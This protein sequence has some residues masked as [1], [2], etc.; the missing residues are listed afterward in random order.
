MS[1]NNP[2]E[3]GRVSEETEGLGPGPSENPITPLGPFGA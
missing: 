1:T 3:L 2:I